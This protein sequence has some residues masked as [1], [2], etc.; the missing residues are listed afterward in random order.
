MLLRPFLCF[1]L[2]LWAV[3]ATAAPENLL[4]QALRLS[5]A[6]DPYWKTLLH[7]D[8]FSGNSRIDDPGFFLSPN[9]KS[10]PTAELEASLNALLLN[11]EDEALC[12]YPAR[13]HWLKQSLG[14][15]DLNYP[16]ERCRELDELLEKMA[17]ERATLIFPGGHLNSPASMF[18]HTLLSI[19]GPYRSPLLSY[20]V[21]YAAFTDESNGVLYAFKGIFGY[22]RGFFSILPYYTKVREYGDL[23][24]RD[25]WEYRLNLT[26]EET[27]QMVRHI[28]ELREIYSDYYFID[29]NCSYN[30]L[31]LLDAARPGL[32]LVKQT[33]NFVIPVDTI[34][35]VTEA[36]LVDRATYR[37]S[38]ADR[39]QQIADGMEAEEKSLAADYLDARVELDESLGK[40]DRIE[41][42][43]LLLNLA[44]EEL[45][46]RLLKGKMAPEQYRTQYVN[47]LQKRSRLGPGPKQEKIMVQRPEKGHRSSRIGIS[48]GVSDGQFFQELNL[49]L[50]Y[51]NL[52][53]PG[54]GFKEG[55]QIE[56]GHLRLRQDNEQGRSRLEE[57]ELLNILS[58]SPRAFPFEPLSWKVSAGFIRKGF[59]RG[60]KLSFELRPGAGYSY[61]PGRGLVYAMLENPWQLSGHFA[62]G[63]TTGLGISGGFID[64]WGERWQINLRLNAAHYPLGEEHSEASVRLDQTITLQENIALI[65]RTSSEWDIRG[66]QKEAS[67]GLN[68]YW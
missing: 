55:A 20:A 38:K 12:R 53:D 59:R 65:I 43:I 23:E 29:E 40:I 26:K 63:F 2:L 16:L 13:F 4:D 18:G 22:Y 57:L 51:H 24:K 27:L 3:P 54:A 5:L 6:Q 17:P 49:R 48:A 32:N 60:D 35:L 11:P 1:V 21:N 14:L 45:E 50:A 52:S 39:M 31:F 7:I 41:G 34:R 36:G 30:L 58:L 37:P 56:F 61:R 47:L 10:D 46:S 67:L 8:G 66:T 42:K 68:L 44:I 9:G 64:S 28:W 19:E 15:E 25:I 62:S 33:E